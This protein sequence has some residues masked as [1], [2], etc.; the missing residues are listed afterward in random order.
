MSPEYTDCACVLHRALEQEVAA[1]VRRVVV[2]QRAEVEHLVAV[3]E[4]DRGEVALGA[5]ARSSS[6]SLR[7]RA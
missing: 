6:D 5:L 7:S 3:A 2:L 1:G 4:V